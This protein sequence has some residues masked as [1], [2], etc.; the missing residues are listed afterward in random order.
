MAYALQDY[1]GWIWP[2]GMSNPTSS[3]MDTYFV[4]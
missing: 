1:S 4:L 2:W 3:Q